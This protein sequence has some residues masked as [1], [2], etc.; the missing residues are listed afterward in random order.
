MR[1]PTYTGSVGDPALLVVAGVASLL[2]GGHVVRQERLVA[3]GAQLVLT[4][5]LLLP[6]CLG[7]LNI[8]L[9]SLFFSA[10]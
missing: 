10:G 9:F 2:L 4:D 5:Y 3:L 6:D 8:T 1:V 7:N